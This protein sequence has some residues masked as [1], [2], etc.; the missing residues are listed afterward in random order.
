MLPSGLI[1]GL[2][3]GLIG[4]FAV[5]GPARY[6]AAQRGGCGAGCWA[7]R[8]WSSTAPA[9]PGGLA[10]LTAVAD[11]QGLHRAGVHADR[12]GRRGSRHVVPVTGAMPGPAASLV[13]APSRRRP[14]AYRDPRRSWSAPTC[15]TASPPSCSAW[16]GWAHGLAEVVAGQA[17]VGEVAHGPADVPG[18]WVIPPGAD[19]SLVEY[20]LQHDTAK[21]L[22]IIQLRDDARYVIIEAQA[23]QDGA[24]TFARAAYFADTALLTIEAE[25]SPPVSGQRRHPAAAP[26]AHPAARRRP[27]APGQP[28]DHHPPSA[29]DK[30]ATGLAPAPPSPG[31]APARTACPPPV[32]VWNADLMPRSG[33]RQR[34]GWASAAAAML[35]VT[36]CGHATPNLAKLGVHVP[37]SGQRVRGPRPDRAV[38]SD[39]QVFPLTGLPASRA[40]AARPAVPRAAGRRDRPARTRLG[41][42]WYSRRPPR[43]CA[44][45][46]FTSP[47]AGN[48]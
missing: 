40:A 4:A 22:R 20:H 10:G 34:L 36:A 30:P 14:G 47:G 26:D 38:S 8:C 46:L 41:L 19:L 25:Q 37:S 44:T 16:P 32:A 18:L 28:A 24:D 3:L 9:R 11:R 13:A 48:R 43:P 1:A 5:L 6:P 31:P 17:T 21:A 29:A 23:T 12:L 35:A 15:R 39:R 42:M 33:H 2:L 7:C 27:A 45:S